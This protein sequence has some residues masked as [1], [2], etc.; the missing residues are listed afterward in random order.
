[1]GKGTTI[2]ARSGR[3]G[4]LWLVLCLILA[5]SAAIVYG[6]LALGI[7][8]VSTHLAYLPI[9][10]TGLWWGRRAIWV[11]LFFSV[12]V[13][14][15][16]SFARTPES[17][18]A[19]VVRAI[20]FLL[21]AVSVGAI[22]E[23]ASAALRAEK[24]ARLELESAQHKLI[25]A[26][27]LACMGQLS[28]GVAHELNNPLAS[29]LIYARLLE[30]QIKPRDPALDDLKVIIDQAARS[31][32]IV[33]GLLNFA[34]QSNVL[35]VPTD[36]PALLREAADLTA[37]RARARR[38]LLEVEAPA[39]LGS[40]MMD[41][42]QMKQVLVNLVDNAIDAVAE[43][44]RVVLRAEF[45]DARD[46]LHIKVVDNGCGIPQENLSRIFTPFFTTK[47]T[48]RGTG[49][50]LAIVYG[51]VKMHFGRIAVESQLGKGSTFTVSL[52][53]DGGGKE[54]VT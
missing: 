5:V 26:D 14:C 47:E 28:A 53:A 33:R 15:L 2:Q 46:M 6:R 4:R 10:L 24:S 50:G 27:R 18:L 7:A 34:R 48:G 23:R 32:D 22:S 39:H 30:K 12:L 16:E 36:V 54:P 1:M 44:G 20:F 41:P 25:E 29:I 35:K 37:P 19:D 40:V 42:S 13:F 3:R 45:S 38:V 31:R 51:I 49:L 11:A 9:V 21:V 43:S 17:W 52:P 8:I